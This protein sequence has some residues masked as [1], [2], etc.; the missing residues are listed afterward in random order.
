MLDLA[1]LTTDTLLSARLTDVV[2]TLVARDRATFRSRL[3]SLDMRF[4]DARVEALRE[5][6]GV[7]PPGEFREWEALRQALQGNEEPESHWCS[8]DRSL[9]LDIPLHVPDDPQALAELLPSYSAGLIAGLFLLSEDASGDR[10]LLSLLPGPGDTLIIFPFIHERSTLHPARTLK[11]FLL[12]EWLS[13][14]EPDPD[15]APGQVGES[16]YEELLDVAREHDERLPAFTP[17][18][19]ESLIAADS[20]RLYQRSHWLTGILWGRP[21]PRLTE[22]LARAPGAADWKLERPWLSRQPLL[23]N[24]WVLAHYFLGNEDACRTVITAAHQS[25]AALTRGI[26][27]LVEGWLNAPGQARLAKLDATTLANLR[28]VVRGSARADQQIS[29]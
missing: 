28:R 14:D 13:E 27:R 24:Y 5:A 10:I 17:G 3:A 18:S 21:G 23:A 7:L 4:T 11:R 16:R 8:E 1:T 6:H 22:Q 19:P 9:R 2:E 20:E 29:N 26:A 25:P 15:E 12:T